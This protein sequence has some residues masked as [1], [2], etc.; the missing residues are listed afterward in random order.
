MNTNSPIFFQSLDPIHVG[1]GGYSL[2]RVD[3]SIVR[4]P[5][6]NIPKIP[7]TA[8]SGAA[9]HYS[10]EMYS[11]MQIIA[12]PSQCQHKSSKIC[13]GQGT[14]KSDEERHC[15]KCPICYTFGY[16]GNESYSGTI[17]IFDA[18]ILLFPIRSI[19]GTI[20]ITTKSLLEDAKII[21]SIPQVPFAINIDWKG[22]TINLGWNLIK[23][24]GSGEISGLSSK[25]NV[26]DKNKVV[27]VDDGT[28]GL[29][30]NGNLEV[31]T[32]NAIDPK[33]H[34]AK[35]K[36]L[37]T[38]EAIPRKTIFMME[39][40]E[41]N[42]RKDKGDYFVIN[43][44]YDERNFEWKTPCDVMICGLKEIER[45]GIGGMGTRGFGR[46][47]ILDNTNTPETDNNVKEQKAE[48]MK[49]E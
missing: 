41:D 34:T 30:V 39:F 24:L 29:I 5:I 43:G 15:G 49:N 14:G 17:N 1:T 9:R 46:F 21:N 35:D 27:V 18:Q 3:N 36:A 48:E 10:A 7:G 37:F 8:L 20:W 44:K 33:T 19:Y 42:Y 32:S 13:V 25:I 16:T 11:K 12:K 45:R 22:K 26:I 47:R 31:R 28:F 23:I 4:E 2:G 40:I 38:Y 6:T